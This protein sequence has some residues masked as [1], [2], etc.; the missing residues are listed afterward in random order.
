MATYEDLSDYT[1][2]PTERLLLN[3]GWLG[4]NVSF[5]TGPTDPSFVR[6]LLV[7]ADNQQNIMRGV[8]YCEFCDEESPIR[9]SAP[10]ERGWVSLGMGEIHVPGQDGTVFAAPSLIIHYIT[11]HDYQPPREFQDAVYSAVDECQL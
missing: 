1:Y 7:L 3:V 9:L 5:A 10:V 8:H 2:Q 11:D 4:A 6:R